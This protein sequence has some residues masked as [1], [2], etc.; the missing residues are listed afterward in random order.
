MGAR[1][2][3]IRYLVILLFFPSMAWAEC[4]QWLVC[5][6]VPRE[7][8]PCSRYPS[9]MD[10]NLSFEWNE[11]EVDGNQALICLSEALPPGPRAGC[12]P[13]SRAQ[14]RLLLAPPREAFCDEGELKFMQRRRDLDPR[15]IRK[16]VQDSAITYDDLRGRNP[17]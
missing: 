5:P 13:A 2:S 4:A 8:E 11:I 10:L 12:I 6:Y 7:E 17:R 15:S 9:I 16:R 1:R 14:M 3:P